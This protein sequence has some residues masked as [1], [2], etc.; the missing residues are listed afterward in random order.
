MGFVPEIKTYD[1]DDDDDDDEWCHL[2]V[3]DD[4]CHSNVLLAVE[5]SRHS[6]P[7]WAARPA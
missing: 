2:T 3:T 6:L 7:A 1:D 4:N 5:P